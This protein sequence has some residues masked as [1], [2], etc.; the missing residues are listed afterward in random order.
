MTVVLPGRVP[1]SIK[2]VVADTD[3]RLLLGR[4]S[5]EQWELLGGRMDSGENARATLIR[6]VRE[7]SGL[8]VEVEGRPLDVGMFDVLADGV[9]WVFVVTY[10]CWPA[11]GT[12]TMIRSVEH[13]DLAWFRPE[14]IPGL[15]SLPAFYKNCINLALLHDGKPSTAVP[16]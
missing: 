15:Q 16:S 1:V 12:D 14:E 5:R 6:E 13:V 2:G 8:A 10:C 7:E 11:N 4:N 9:S 3:G